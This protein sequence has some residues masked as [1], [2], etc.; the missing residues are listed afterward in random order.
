MRFILTATIVLAGVVNLHAQGRD[1]VMLASDQKTQVSVPA[2]WTE[3]ELNDVAEI[4]VGNAEDSA[5]MIVINELKE[6][7]FGWNLEKHS[8]VTLGGLIGTLAFPTVD[9]PRSIK[10]GGVPPCNTKWRA[11]SKDRK[12]STCTQP[13]MVRTT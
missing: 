5:Y 3:L 12:S 11:R 9:G 7:L 4:E 10:V 8:R 6:D 13:S 1:K 2:S